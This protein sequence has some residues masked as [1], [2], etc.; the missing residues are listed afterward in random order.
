MGVW[1]KGGDFKTLLSQD[2]V[3]KRLLTQEEL[4]TAFNIRTH[5]KHVD[6]IFQ[7]IFGE[8]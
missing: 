2:E 1:E 8:S 7:R 5:L 4:E 6:N 3:I